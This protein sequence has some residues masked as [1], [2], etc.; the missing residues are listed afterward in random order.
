L[1]LPI[2]YFYPS[3][4]NYFNPWIIL[5]VYLFYTTVHNFNYSILHVNDVHEKHHKN[6]T[7][8]IGPD[9]CDILFNTKMDDCIENT[10]HYIGNVV[11]SFIIVFLFSNYYISLDQEEKSIIL[12][13]FGL[14]FTISSIFILL[15]TFYLNILNF[16]SQ[17]NKKKLK[18][19]IKLKNKKT[20][21]NT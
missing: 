15:V 10:D 7:T 13:I 1:I 17:F 16:L 3:L 19:K 12:W 5:F 21:K 9:I 14:I 20:K 4:K 6:L 2:S 18:N 11:L 8:N